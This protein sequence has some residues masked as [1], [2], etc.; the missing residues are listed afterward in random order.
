MYGLGAE[1][2]FAKQCMQLSHKALVNKC[3]NAKRWEDLI[4]SLQNEW[5][6]DENF[7]ACLLQ[8]MEPGGD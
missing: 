4:S 5:Q 1:G 3:Q 6:A 7:N 8:P 2:K